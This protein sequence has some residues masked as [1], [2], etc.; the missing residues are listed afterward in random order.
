VAS[1][2][3]GR[4]PRS[5]DEIDAAWL[6]R[7][8]APR[9][10]G[11]RVADVAVVRREEAT[12]DHAWLRIRYDE[13]A[14]APASMFCKLLPCEP[15][16]REAI[17]RTGMGLREALF[18][19]RLAPR[20]ALRVPAVHSVL[21]DERDGSFLLLMEDLE[22]SGCTVSEGP[23]GVAPG[24]ARRALEDLAALHV[25][26]EDEARRRSEAAWVPEPTAESDYGAV[27]LRYGL[28]HHRDRLSHSF[29][30]LARLY[31]DE[32]LALHSVWHE[33]PKTVIHGDP[34]IGNLFDDHGRTGF[35]DWGLI[36]VT[37]PLRDVSYFLAMALSVDDR[38][39]HERELLRHYLEARARLGGARIGFDEAW[40]AH[41]VHAAYTVVASCQIV[42]FPDGIGEER[43]VFADA[44]LA[45]ASAAVEDLESRAA[46]RRVAGV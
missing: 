15:R 18:Y 38:R 9:H 43:R 6:S 42:T 44:F 17:A 35:F 24:S 23:P 2:S 22:A 20:L 41:R 40:L 11:V 1:P 29:A 34:H 26:F 36:Q 4:L 25:G 16:R 8:L 5:P 33:G 32:R 21:H 10:P 39:R 13:P 46:L 30:E 19:E 27:R 12:N 14:G 7:A 37:T 3:Q 31:V 45:R 28:E